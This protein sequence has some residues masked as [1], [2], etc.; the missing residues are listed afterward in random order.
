MV[1]YLILNDM[2]FYV[3]TLT[4]IFDSYLLLFILNLIIIG[5]LDCVCT[6]MFV[7]YR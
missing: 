1:K 3:L 2:L 5:L 4:L 7:V 6:S